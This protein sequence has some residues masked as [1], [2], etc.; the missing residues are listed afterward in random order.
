MNI[1]RQNQASGLPVHPLIMPSKD[2]GKSQI[3]NE[4]NFNLHPSGG[5]AAI[6]N[7]NLVWVIPAT[8]QSLLEIN[9]YEG[10]RFQPVKFLNLELLVISNIFYFL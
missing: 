8:G 6:P 9:W 5:L 7:S 10:S 3:Q 2:T 1:G 4:L